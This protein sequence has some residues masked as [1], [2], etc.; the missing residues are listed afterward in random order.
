MDRDSYRLDI[1]IEITDNTKAQL[2][3]IDREF[4]AIIN[5]VEDEWGQGLIN[6]LENIP[7]V[8]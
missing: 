7:K 3:K 4:K 6:A 2:E 8:K 5:R 1:K